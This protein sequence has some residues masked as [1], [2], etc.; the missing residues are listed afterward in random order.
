MEHC[1]R[2]DASLK[3]FVARPTIGTHLDPTAGFLGQQGPQALVGFFKLPQSH[4]RIPGWQD[5]A[6]GLEH[7]L[8]PAVV[9]LE[10]QHVRLFQGQ[11]A[12][13]ES[14]PQLNFIMARHWLNASS[15]GHPQH[16][17][18]VKSKLCITLCPRLQFVIS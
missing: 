2:F 9:E 18:V 8:S 11:A 10:T 7:L 17:F 6:P 5:L 4:S 1:C 14:V 3:S 12:A 15:L 16:A 13:D